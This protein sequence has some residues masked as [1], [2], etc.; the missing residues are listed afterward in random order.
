MSSNKKNKNPLKH[1]FKII[2]KQKTGINPNQLCLKYSLKGPAMCV[3]PG[4]CQKIPCTP[5]VYY[6]FLLRTVGRSSVWKEKDHPPE[7]RGGALALESPPTHTQILISSAVQRVGD[8]GARS[9][10]TFKKI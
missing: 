4:V 3:P 9:T 5:I 7:Q 8:H 1:D 10:V 6:I 2:F